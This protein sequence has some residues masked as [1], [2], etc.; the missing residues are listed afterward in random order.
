[1][2][3]YHCGSDE[4]A[5]ILAHKPEWVRGCFVMD[6][7]HVIYV[8]EDGRG[9]EEIAMEVFKKLDN[10]GTIK[11]QQ[12]N[13]IKSEDL[14]RIL[15]NIGTMTP[16]QD[17]LMKE[18]LTAYFGKVKLTDQVITLLSDFT[19]KSIYW[20]LEGISKKAKQENIRSAVRAMTLYD[21]AQLH[22]VFMEIDR[23]ESE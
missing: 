18:I 22:D 23:E 1:M 19:T 10:A 9:H 11:H 15:N 2:I 3:C 20:L 13:P 14:T 5:S 17:H 16:R 21:R 12:Y 6:N 4:K 8:F 7:I